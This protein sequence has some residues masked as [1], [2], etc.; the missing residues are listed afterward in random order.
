MYVPP[1]VDPTLAPPGK[2]IMSCFIQYAPYSRRKGTWE[3]RR[4]EFGETV[5]DTIEEYIPS[6]RNIILHRQ[7]LSPWDLEQMIGLTGGNIFHGELTPDQ[8]LFLRPTPGWAQYRMPLKGLYL[9]G[10]G[11]H[12]GGRRGGRQSGATD[13]PER[14]E[15]P[16][17][18]REVLT[19][20]R[21]HIPAVRRIPEPIRSSARSDPRDAAARPRIAEP[22]RADGS[23]RPRA[24]LPATWQTRDATDAPP[25]SDGNPRLSERVVRDRVA[26]S[27]LRGRC[28]D[29]NV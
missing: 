13:F 17:G 5:L 18:T 25:A 8:H 16:G 12:P 1:T 14:P 11:A 4:E 24:P 19:K 20:R 7:F 21:G 15:D 2:H 28:I 9:C 29:G 6:I 26:Q 23:P 3:E 22:R 10:S 27:E